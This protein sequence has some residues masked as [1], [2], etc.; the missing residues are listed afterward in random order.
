LSQI[1]ARTKAKEAPAA[2]RQASNGSGASLES[3]AMLF[4]VQF[5]EDVKRRGAF[6]ITPAAL[7]LCGS[8]G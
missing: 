5:L 6:V 7:L 3:P 1:T 8:L 4:G 2:H